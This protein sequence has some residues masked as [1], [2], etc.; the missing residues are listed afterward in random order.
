MATQ[1]FALLLFVTATILTNFAVAEDRS[2]TGVGNNVSHTTLGS[3]NQPL[4]RFNYKADFPNNQMIS[5]AQ[6]ANAR[7]ISNAVDV[8]TSS[9]K[10]ARGL[11]DYIWAW[12]QFLTHDTD[13]TTDS[14]GAAVNGSAPIAVNS[15]S[16]ALGPNPIPFI[17]D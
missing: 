9:Q 12:G 8:Q 10:S 11:S 14:N 4:I 17:R 13:L 15:A 7:D 16:D 5:D 3:A 1:R 2:I 6:R